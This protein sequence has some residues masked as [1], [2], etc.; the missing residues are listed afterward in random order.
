MIVFCF[1][2]SN[3][4]G[5]SGAELGVAYGAPRG[6]DA[7]GAGAVRRSN[8]AVLRTALSERIDSCRRGYD[9]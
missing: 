2:K 4:R 6:E 9:G 5:S 8:R 7:V 1:E 3:S